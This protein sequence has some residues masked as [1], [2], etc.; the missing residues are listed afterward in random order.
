[1]DTEGLEA[2]T[3]EMRT[4]SKAQLFKVAKVINHYNKPKRVDLLSLNIFTSMLDN[5]TNSSYGSLCRTKRNC[6]ACS[7]Q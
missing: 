2:E 4:G 1:M 5:L 3:R 6:V 7:T